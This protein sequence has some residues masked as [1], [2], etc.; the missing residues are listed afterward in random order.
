[1]RVWF[2]ELWLSGLWQLMTNIAHTHKLL[3]MVTLLLI[4]GLISYDLGLL[5]LVFIYSQLHWTSPMSLEVN[6]FWVKYIQWFN[7]KD[8]C[9]KA[10][11]KEM[12]PKPLPI[13]T[14]Q[15]IGQQTMPN[16]YTIKFVLRW[17]KFLIWHIF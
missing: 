7:V 14:L 4:F 17:T 8:T 6:T 11:R 2:F 15:V 5:W 3:F 12:Q 9:L 13:L 1:M 10:Y 16:I